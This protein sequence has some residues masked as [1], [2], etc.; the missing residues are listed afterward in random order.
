MTRMPRMLGAI[1]FV[2]FAAIRGLFFQAEPG[3]F[4]AITSSLPRKP[5][6][7]G[8]VGLGK[9]RS[10]FTSTFSQIGHSSAG[11]RLRRE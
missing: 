1:H 8:P 5:L 6:A 2:A 10:D 9:R 3:A 11:D 4:P 7:L